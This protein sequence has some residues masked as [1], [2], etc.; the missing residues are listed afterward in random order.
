MDFSAPSM[1]KKGFTAAV[2]G[3]T[4]YMFS[5]GVGN[6]ITQKGPVWTVGM[7]LVTMLYVWRGCARGVKAVSVVC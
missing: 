3:F 6:V 5:H 4:Y 2:A 1:I 7:A